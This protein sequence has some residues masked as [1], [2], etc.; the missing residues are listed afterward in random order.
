MS[1]CRSPP[2][3]EVSG[4][5]PPV[6]PEEVQSPKPAPPPPGKEDLRAMARKQLTRV[7]QARCV[8]ACWWVHVWVSVFCVHVGG[9]VGAH[10]CTCWCVHVGGWV[11]ARVC[12]CWCVHVWVCVFSVLEW[13]FMYWC[14]CRVTV[15][16]YLHVCGVCAKVYTNPTLPTVNLLDPTLPLPFP[17]PCSERRWWMD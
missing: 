3:F 17:L 12:T 9:W 15:L 13:A 5:T 14:T 16:V 10:V 4:D 8:C 1:Y 2:S 6:K 7:L 11:G